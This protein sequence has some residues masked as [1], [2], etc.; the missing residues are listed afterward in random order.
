[1]NYL[2]RLGLSWLSGLTVFLGGPSGVLAQISPALVNFSAGGPWSTPVNTA[3]SV[4]VHDHHDQPYQ[5]TSSWC[6]NNIGI[7]VY[8]F[9]R[10]QTGIRDVTKYRTRTIQEPYT[11]YRQERVCEFGSCYYRQVPYTEYRTRTI[12]EPYVVQEPIY[13]DFSEELGIEQIEFPS[14]NGSI[15][16]NGG[17]VSPELAGFLSGLNDANYTV[18]LWRRGGT[19]I[20][21]EIGRGT[22]RAW[23]S[24]Y[25]PSQVNPQ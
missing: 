17:G 14:P 10:E 4:C 1:M 11:A 8:R 7:T 15:F 22:V 13:Q 25:T 2:G 9:W 6:T 21:Y 16:Y 5:F 12:Q 23:K 18:R 3:Q 24:V 20:S 19:V